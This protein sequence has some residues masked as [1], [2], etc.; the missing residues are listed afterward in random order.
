M[1]TPSAQGGVDVSPPSRLFKFR[2]FPS[3]YKLEGAGLEYAQWQ[4]EQ[5]FDIFRGRLRLTKPE[6]FNDPFEFRPSVKIVEGPRKHVLC[7][8]R[9]YVMGAARDRLPWKQRLKLLQNP[10][11][12]DRAA[13]KLDQLTAASLRRMREEIEIYCL[14]ANETR[15]LLWS[16]Y[17]DGHRGIAIHFDATRPPFCLAWKVQYSIEYPVVVAGGDRSTEE[18]WRR[19][20]QSL[21]VKDRDWSYEEEYRFLAPLSCQ[22]IETLSGHGV[23]HGDGY[24]HVHPSII[25]GVTLGAK[26]P[27]DVEADLLAFLE[28]ERRDV[29]V[30]RA[31]LADA[32]FEV[33][34]S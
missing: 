22:S 4:R 10:A 23:L 34:V 16:H 19:L 21:L 20:E 14:S 13:A 7:S 25:C 12:V 5:V 33:V 3:L 11:Q 26:M 1:T 31:K 30:R 17:A 9:K 18:N 2:S 6:S 32:R 15:P 28:R 8:S 29:V 24:L 27:A